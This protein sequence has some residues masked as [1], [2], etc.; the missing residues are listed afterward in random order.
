MNEIIHISLSCPECLKPHIDEGEWATRPHKT[1]LCVDD[2]KGKGCGHKWK[3]SGH[4]TVGV[5]TVCKCT[6]WN[7]VVACAVT[8]VETGKGGWPLTAAVR[9]MQ[10]KKV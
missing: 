4:A 3:P 8:L 9:E 10:A 2:A 7:D 5:E 1:H 6:H